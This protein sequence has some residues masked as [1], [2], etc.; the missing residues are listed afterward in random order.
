MESATAINGTI[1]HLALLNETLLEHPAPDEIATTNELLAILEETMRRRA[2]NMRRAGEQRRHR[3]AERVPT[4]FTSALMRGCI[5]RGQDLL[6]GMD[7]HLPGVYERGLTNAVNALAAIEQTVFQE[8]SLTLGELVTAMRENFPDAALRQRLR[9]APKWGNDDERA[10]RWAQALVALRE[11]VL[12]ETDAA[13]GEARHM[14]C[15]VVRSLHHLDG[16]RIAASPDGR[17][18]QTPVADSIGAET[19]T[20]RRGPTA[21]L[22]SVLKLD[23][24]KNYRGGTNLNLTLPTRG[25]SPDAVLALAET[26]FAR[27]G[28]ELQVNVLDPGTLREARE[29]PERHG[30]LVVR[31]AGFSARFVDL[32]PAEQDE[33]IARAQAAAE[34]SPATG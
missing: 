26:F 34:G 5:R 12:D 6:V 27:G 8:Q 22:N 32:P 25:A 14:V 15:H 31:V 4:P 16:R 3:M 24:A 19:G 11:R 29:H 20:A 17:L 10:D 30:E 28:Q 9:S 2:M 18:A 1:Q 33:L 21:I 7:Y 23:A 13:F